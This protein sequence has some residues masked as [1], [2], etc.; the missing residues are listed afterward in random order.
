MAHNIARENVHTVAGILF[1]VYSIGT[2]QAK[3]EDDE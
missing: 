3:V 2:R 1:G